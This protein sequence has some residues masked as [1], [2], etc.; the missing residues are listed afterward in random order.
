VLGR[1]IG[2]SLLDFGIFLVAFFAV[3]AAT[4]NIDTDNGLHA[5]LNGFPAFAWFA[6][7]FLY[8]WLLEANSGQT[9]GK[10]WLGICVVNAAG[11]SPGG[12]KA[13]GRTVLRII[14]FLPFFYLLGFIVVLATRGRAGRLGDLAAGT[15]VVASTDR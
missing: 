9:L 8:Y 10:R 13:A 5:Y 11:E 4:N 7:V 6:F 2:A 15:Y 3:A 14:D 1:R 12:G